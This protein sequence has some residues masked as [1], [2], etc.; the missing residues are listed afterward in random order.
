MNTVMLTRDQV[1]ERSK[2]LPGF[3]R[4]I[5][6]IMA[7]LDDPEGSLHVLSRCIEH[8]PLITARVL[9]AANVA[10]QRTGNLKEVNNIYTATS[11]IGMSRVRE[12]TLISRVGDF[13]AGM[14]RVGIPLTF[15]HH[16]MAVGVC[17]Q[18]LA[19]HIE[20]PVSSDA[21]LIAGLLHDIG[22]LWLYDF[23]SQAYR[24]CWQQART[25]ASG[26]ESIE[27]EHFG[28]DHSTIGAWMAEYWALPQGIVDAIQGHH[29]PDAAQA[30]PLVSLVHLAEVLSN[31]L[32]LSGRDENRVTS[33]SSAACDQLGLV[34]DESCHALFGRIDART[35]HASRFFSAGTPG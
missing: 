20:V 23:N 30:T 22:Q 29:A 27:R 10:A 4:A 12:I 6:E 11:L 3:P 1:I 28:V 24:A 7:T 13:V 15:W 17:C 35:Q 2:K 34:W 18:E 5:A 14:P 9:S 26:I 8:D 19:L 33:L 31:A 21:A 32:D 16:C 25:H